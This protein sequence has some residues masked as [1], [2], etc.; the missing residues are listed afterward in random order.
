M[1]SVTCPRKRVGENVNQRGKASF[2]DWTKPLKTKKKK[3]DPSRK[4]RETSPPPKKSKI[5]F[6]FEKAG[7]FFLVLVVMFCM[8]GCICFVGIWGV[9]SVNGFVVYMYVFF[10]SV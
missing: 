9:L 6:S 2:I 8:G 3:V 10:Y 1:V 4:K 5:L 7:G